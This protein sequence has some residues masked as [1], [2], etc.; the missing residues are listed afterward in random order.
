MLH[1]PADPTVRHFHQI[2]LWPLE[3][4]PSGHDDEDPTPWQR[5]LEDQAAGTWREVDDEFP[6]EPAL[7]QERHY[8]EFVTFLP[9]VQRFLYGEGATRGSGRGKSPIRILR[10]TDVKRARLMYP[11]EPEPVV[12]DV[13]HVDLYFFFDIDVIVLVVELTGDNL[14]LARVQD[15]LYRLGRAYPTHWGSDGHG[16]HCLTRAEWLGS[17]G[18]VLAVS[19]YE[20]REKFLV[21]VGRYRAPAIA[22]H[23]EYLLTPMVP[24]HT[25]QPGALRYRPVEYHRMPVMGYLAVDRLNALTRADFVRIGLVTPP[26]PPG[27]LPVSERH[28]ADFEARY[29]YDR[30][31]DDAS[32]RGTRT[33]CSGEAM[34]IV[35]SAGDPYFVEHEAGLRGHFRHQHF[36]LFLIPHFHKA[37]LVLL[38]D[39]LVGAV[40]DLDVGDTESIKRFKRRIRQLKEVFLRFT[41]RYWFHE[42]TDQA[43]ARA[44]YRMCCEALGTE[45]LYDEVRKEIQD[46]SEYLD[47]DSLR[48]QSNMVI[49]LTVV[50]TAGLIGTITTGYFGMNLLAEADSHLVRKI[51]YFVLGTAATTALTGWTI[52]RSK[53]LSDFLEALADERLSAREKLAAF[54]AV[55]RRPRNR[56]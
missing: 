49:R 47:S 37:A 2:L 25:M 27:V 48:R 26:G 24:H 8:S 52:A 40:A 55:W 39:R 11:D 43:Q 7:F 41:H 22:A 16:G 3:L 53:R 19:D 45:R 42:V 29:C 6:S 33:M 34:A 14:P 50:T 9:Y 13:A 36:L 31:W 28:A 17:D 54:T 46:M 56:E 30:Y 35:G 38:S 5:L 12:L 1:A 51:V 15:T 4:M 44:L 21:H 23:W 20:K 10:R 32:A 18:T